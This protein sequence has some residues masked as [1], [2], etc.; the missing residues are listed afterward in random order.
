LVGL[1]IP[2][3]CY[4]IADAGGIALSIFK[5]LSCLVSPELPDAAVLFQEGTG[6][7]ARR[8]RCSRLFLAGVRGS[9]HIYVNISR[10]IKSKGLSLVLILF[11]KIANHRFGLALG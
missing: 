9:T 5:L 3:Q 2:I 4:G 11:W 7:H 8:F 6:I 10:A 1:I